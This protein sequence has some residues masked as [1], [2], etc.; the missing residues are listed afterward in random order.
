LDHTDAKTGKVCCAATGAEEN[1][2]HW[3]AELVVLLAVGVILGI[4][5]F[6]KISRAGYPGIMGLAMLVPF[7]NIIMLFYLGFKMARVAR[8]GD[9]TKAD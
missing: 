5:R 7:L 1:A 9:T 8:I 6:W 4:L 2:L 3:L